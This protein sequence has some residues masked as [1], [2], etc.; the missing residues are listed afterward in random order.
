MNENQL[1]GIPN[2]TSGYSAVNKTYVD[3]E[4]IK[5]KQNISSGGNFVKKSGDTVTGDC[6]GIS[7]RPTARLTL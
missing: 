4:I 1:I 6:N 3:N 5:V 2:P 7:D